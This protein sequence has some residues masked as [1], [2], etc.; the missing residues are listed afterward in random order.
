MND[1]PD[2]GARTAEAVWECPRCPNRDL[3]VWAEDPDTDAAD[4]WECDNCSA[5]GV[6]AADGQPVIP[7]ESL[8]ERQ[9]H[10][11]WQRVA[12]GWAVDIQHAEAVLGTDTSSRF[13]V[14]EREARA[15]ADDLAALL[16]L[17]NPVRIGDDL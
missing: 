2:D 9:A 3:T 1:R 10:V 4:Y 5:H 6:F 15:F 16:I 14:F 12:G 8:P 17:A 13:F 7:L 11:T